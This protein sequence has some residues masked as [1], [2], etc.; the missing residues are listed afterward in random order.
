MLVHDHQCGGSSPGGGK[1][2]KV[3]PFNF[4]ICINTTE[5]KKEE[6][7]KIEALHYHPVSYLFF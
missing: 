3:F 2:E 7:P 1:V 5:K 4:L 6:S